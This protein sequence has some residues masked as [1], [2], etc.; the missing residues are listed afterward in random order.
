M[1]LREGA[2]GVAPGGQEDW[3]YR[4]FRLS[5][6]RL[7]LDGPFGWCHS[8][9]EHFEAALR[10]LRELEG[11][12]WQEI[13]VQQKKQNHRMERAAISSEAQERLEQIGFGDSEFVYS[14]RVMKA[15]RLW[16]V[17][18]ARDAVTL[19]LLWCDPEHKVYPMN[20]TDN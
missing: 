16:G 8:T 7:D 12:S 14:F 17:R 9:R 15:F 13:L 19:L 5:L 10:R 3:F 2:G 1:L 20:I 18:D 6:R 4:P 11:L